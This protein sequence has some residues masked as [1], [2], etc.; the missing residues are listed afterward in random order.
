MVDNCGGYDCVLPSSVSCSLP[1]SGDP[2]TSCIA[3][4]PAA[5]TLQSPPNDYQ[6]PYASPPTTLTLRWNATSDFG[7]SSNQTTS[8]A[9]V[10]NYALCIRSELSSTCN[11]RSSVLA[12]TVTSS[13]FTPS[14]SDA[15]YNPSTGIGTYYWKVT[16]TNGSN[17]TTTTREWKFT[18]D[19]RPRYTITGRLCFTDETSS[20]CSATSAC[21][22]LNLT[23]TFSGNMRLSGG[24]NPNIPSAAPLTQAVSGSNNLSRTFVDN[25]IA[26][27]NGSYV[28]QLNQDVNSFFFIHN[29]SIGINSLSGNTTRNF[30]VTLQNDHWWQTA[31][32]DTFVKGN[33]TS[34]IPPNPTGGAYFSI[35]D[36]TKSPGVPVIGGGT[37][38]TSNRPISVTNFRALNTESRT[39]QGVEQPYNWFGYFKRTY[40]IVQLTNTTFGVLPN[41][42]LN[43]DQTALNNIDNEVTGNRI[44][45]N[46]NYNDEHLYYHNG[47]VTI[48]SSL[49]IVDGEKYTIFIEGNLTINHPSDIVNITVSEGSFLGFIVRGNITFGAKARNIAGL[50]VAN[51]TLTV[52][53]PPDSDDVGPLRQ[54]NGSGIFVGQSGVNLTRDL[55]SPSHQL[56]NN[57]NPA[58][59]F[60][61]RPD[62][63]ANAPRGLKRIP[64]KWREIQPQ[65][66]PL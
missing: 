37:I 55:K 41:S 31:F 58:E 50:Y 48:S 63:V 20:N 32:G 52:E 7:K 18:V 35:G 10:P 40:E 22:N 1:P 25:R 46:E 62:F 23:Q 38:N 39:I 12:S 13:T 66:L 5:F 28:L 2:G 16:A 27:F 56:A 59:R 30:C 49:N 9:P 26:G 15:G 11:I 4:A 61:Y 53:N 42:L 3:Q 33:L 43:L 60:T 45:A 34:L 29:S 36:G 19:L 21:L 14:T 6:S 54:F 8:C 51:D 57:L 64:I 44:T 65:P 24:T 17:W 47:D